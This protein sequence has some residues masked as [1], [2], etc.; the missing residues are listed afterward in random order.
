MTSGS[1]L[2]HCE[3]PP[4]PPPAEQ[5]YEIDKGGVHTPDCCDPEPQCPSRG[6][7]GIWPCAV[8]FTAP[9]RRAEFQETPDQ[10]LI[11]M[12]MQSIN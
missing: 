4:P 11:G 5:P 8:D 7:P 12:V 9:P 2:H 3:L 6:K 1:K 10:K